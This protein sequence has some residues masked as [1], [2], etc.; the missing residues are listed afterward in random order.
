MKDFKTYF[1]S[2]IGKKQVMAVTGLLLCGFLLTHLLGNLL[3]LKGF[4][5]G[6]CPF[7]DY[8]HQLESLGVVL[9]VIEAV[10]FLMFVVHIGLAIRL[11]FENRMAR[12]S[13]KY[14]V[15]ASSGDLTLASRSMIYTGMWVLVFLVLHLIHFKF[16]DRPADKGLYGVVENHFKNPLNVAYYLLTFVLLGTHLYHGVQ[17]IF[18]TFG[19]S[20]KKYNALVKKLSAL[21]VSLIVAGYSVIPL[22][23]VLNRGISK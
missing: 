6:I 7:N 15:Q 2:S 5:N 19:L 13:E 11:T 14:H 20:H 22:W 9:Y 4:N 3:I 8:A 21:Y 1:N 23:F 12:G 10:L 18:Q 17:S 16:A